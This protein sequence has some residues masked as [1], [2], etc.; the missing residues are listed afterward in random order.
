MPFLLTDALRKTIATD[1]KYLPIVAVTFQPESESV[2]F[3]FRVLVNGLC[4]LSTGGGPPALHMPEMT[5]ESDDSD[6]DENPLP[7][8]SRSQQP[9]SGLDADDKSNCSVSTN[10]SRESTT[11]RALESETVP[12]TDDM[13]TT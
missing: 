9:E 2:T 5:D 3:A 13:D 11:S 7:E 4:L 6:Q 12:P 8:Q 10:S 1:I